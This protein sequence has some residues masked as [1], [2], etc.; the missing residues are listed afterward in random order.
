MR[1]LVDGVYFQLAHNGISRAWSSILSRLID[2]PEVE[3]VVLD[4]GDCPDL[5]GCR[6]IAFPSYTATSTPADSLLIDRIAATIRADVFLST[7]FTTPVTLPSVLVMQDAPMK[8]PGDERR[9]RLLQ[10]RELAI[11]H[12]RHYL[13][14]TA[15][16]RAEIVQLSHGLREDR[17]VTTHCGVDERLFHPRQRTEIAVCLRTHDIA[18]P[19]VV[20]LPSFRDVSTDGG[21]AI[22]RAVEALG[23]TIV[24]VGRLGKLLGGAARPDHPAVQTFDPDGDDLARLYAGAE[25]AILDPDAEFG[26]PGL[27]AM[28]C[29]CPVLP[30]WGDLVDDGSSTATLRVGVDGTM[31]EKAIVRAREPTERTQLVE[32]GYERAASFNW[33]RVVQDLHRR[34]KAAADERGTPAM[35]HFFEEWKRLRSIQTE[36][37]TLV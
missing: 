22:T 30:I 24:C 17:V 33:D 4:R 1:V 2:I 7:Y 36:V 10:E 31:I 26:A 6:K 15:R 20:V 21:G 3:V 18:E 25:A 11:G 23:S 29:G 37:D 5:P 35:R 9:A 32:A 13:C 14:L 16:A 12:A 28:A 34:L 19:Y 8:V 27:E